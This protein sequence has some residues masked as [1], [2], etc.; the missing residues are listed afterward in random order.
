MQLVPLF[1]VFYMVN[2]RITSI[3]TLTRIDGLMAKQLS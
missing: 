1:I 2:R 3:T